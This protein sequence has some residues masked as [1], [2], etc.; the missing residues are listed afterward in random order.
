MNR[1]KEINRKG[2]AINLNQNDNF[3]C[4]VWLFFANEVTQRFRMENCESI[5]K[6]LDY[7]Y[8]FAIRH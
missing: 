2:Y 4:D 6:A 5:D 7:A 3:T 8:Y 1:I